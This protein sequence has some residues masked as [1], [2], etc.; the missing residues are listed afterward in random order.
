MATRCYEDHY[1]TASFRGVEFVCEEANSEHGR[2]GAEGEFPFGENTAYADLGRRIRTYTLSARFQ[3][4][5]HIADSQLLIAACE[6]PGPGILVHPTR[7]VINAACKRLR[8][9]DK[10]ETEQGVTYVDM[11]FVEANEWPNGLSFSTSMLS[12]GVAD[13]IGASRTSF[14]AVYNPAAVQPYR[15]EAVL[16]TAQGQVSNISTAYAVATIDEVSEESRNRILLDF[17]RVENSSA[18]ASTPAVMDRTLAMGM[19]AVANEMTGEVQYG[20]FRAL[21]NGA[22]KTSAYPNPAGA[23][24]NAVYSQVRIISAAYMAEAA[25]EESSSRTGDVFEQIDAITAILDEE[26]RIARQ[27]CD[28]CLFLAL[29]KFRGQ[30]VSALYSKAYNSPSVAQYNFGGKVHPLVAAYSIYNDATR[31]R[32]LEEI[33]VVGAAGRIGNPVLAA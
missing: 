26:I 13:I 10:P 14:M 1:L 11:D 32:E 29:T 7:G 12:L 33:N 6:F 30:V 2:R 19:T 31:L 9:R 20:V 28:N 8:V 25:L 3:E 21:A 27:R 22:A 4:N 24:E 5:S 17:A 15:T 23:S 18:L 16:D